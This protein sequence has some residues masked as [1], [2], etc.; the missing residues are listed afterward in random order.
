MHGPFLVVPLSTMPSWLLEFSL[1]APDINIVTYIGD[2]E[3]RN[4]ISETEWCY[5]SSNRLKFNA[6]LT[7]Y[8]IVLNDSLLLNSLSWAVLLVDEAHRTPFQNNL[9]ELWALLHFIMRANWEEFEHMHDNAASK[10]YTKHHR[11]LEPYILRRVKKDVENLL[12][13]SG[14]LML[15]DKLLVRLKEIGHRELIFSQMVRML[16]ILTEYLSYRHL[17][18]QRLDGSIKG[19]VRRQALEHFNAEGSQDFFFLL[20]TR[21]GG[22]GINL[23]TADTV[24]I[25]DL[26]WNPQNDLQAQA[27]THKIGQK[28]RVNIYRLVTKGSIEEDIVERAKQKMVL[29]HLCDIDEILRIAET[30]DEAPTTVGNEHLSA[31]KD[32]EK[33]KEIGYL[34]LSPRSK[35]TLQKLNQERK[36]KKDESDDGSDEDQVRKCERPHVETKKIRKLIKSCKRFPNPMEHIDALAGDADKKNRRLS[37]KF[38]GVEVNAKSV[39]A[40]SKGLDILD[41]MKN[42]EKRSKFTLD[43]KHVK[44]VNF[45]FDWDITDDLKFYS[46]LKIKCKEK[47]RPVKKVLKALDDLDE[48][49]NELLYVNHMQECL[50]EIGSHIGK[51][52][53]E[54]KDP[55]KIREWRRFSIFI[56]LITNGLRI[57]EKLEKDNKV[58]NRNKNKDKIRDKS[59]EDKKL[60]KKSSLKRKSRDS[61][62]LEKISKK[63]RTSN[64]NS[65]ALLTTPTSI[66]ITPPSSTNFSNATRSYYDQ[67]SNE[68]QANFY[69]HRNRST[70]YST[71]DNRSFHQVETLMLDMKGTYDNSYRSRPVFREREREI[72]SDMRLYD[73]IRYQQAYAAYGQAAA[74]NFYAPELYSRSGST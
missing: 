62:D 35:K 64:S 26:D 61:D 20:S 13:G 3:S 7:T 70:P 48:K 51:C 9:K 28:N 50:I 2:V 30:R 52:L 5:E 18:F 22:L 43:L 67:S 44:S 17:P 23:A 47:M 63:Q 27:R 71:S 1:W 66:L 74:A 15:L 12:Q 65:D 40:C 38:G 58:K 69:H 21:T 4:I 59:K 55:D 46:K 53:E 14:K 56:L 42:E 32:E 24:I 45:D 39:L 25:F 73:K 60:Q 37:I 19:D 34:Y 10:G 36:R 11:Q 29:D 54:Y 68:Y 49:K 16:D 8:K 41:N 72:N 33:A 31:F 57:T 6:I